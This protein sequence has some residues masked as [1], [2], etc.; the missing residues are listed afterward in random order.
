[1][2]TWGDSCRSS[3]SDHEVYEGTLSE[4]Q[5]QSFTNFPR[6][7]L[8]LSALPIR[9][10]SASAGSGRVGSGFTCVVPSE[11]SAM[12]VHPVVRRMPDSAMVLPASEAGC[13]A[14]AA[15]ADD[16]DPCMTV[17]AGASTHGILSSNIV[18]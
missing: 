3:D 14:H 2:L 4:R 5:A 1:M 15:A 18:A 13:A 9:I 12:T 11:S 6:K 8:S 7:R 16:H 17:R 10:I